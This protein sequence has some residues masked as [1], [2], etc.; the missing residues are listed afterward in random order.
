MGCW[1]VTVSGVEGGGVQSGLLVGSNLWSWGIQGG[2][3]FGGSLWSRWR[4]Q[5]I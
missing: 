2:L 4:R 5:K 1:L 3:L